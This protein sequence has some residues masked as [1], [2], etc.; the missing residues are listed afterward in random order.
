MTRRP[1]VGWLRHNFLPASETFLYQSL[2]AVSADVDVRVFALQRRY[3]EK[4]PDADVLALEGLP[5]GRLETALYRLTS[6]SPRWFAFARGVD[7]LHAHMGYTAAHALLARARTGRPLVVS[8]YGRD[9]TLAQSTSRFTDPSY[10][11]Y[12][13]LW[14]RVLTSAD[15]VCVLSEDM[16]AQLVAV[17][18]PADR[19]R[20]VRLGIDL[21][22]FDV[23]R[24]VRTGP[25]T[26]LMVGRE[27]EKKG[28]DD[29]LR[30][31]AAA[32]AAGADL[33]IVLLGTGGP[34]QRALRALADE[35]GLEVAWPDPATRVPQAMAE[36][37]ILM[38]PSRT[39]ANGDREGTPTVIC[40]AGAARLPVVATRHA[41]IPEQVE[42][43]VT[44]LL[45]D[46]RDVAGLAAHLVILAADPDRRRALGEAG[47]ARM[48][49]GFSVEAH[50]RSLSATYR[51]LL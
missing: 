39:A 12:A 19:I 45:A 32:K 42:D 34:D 13:A 4:F 15:R 20:I 21:A 9:V 31:C 27:I 18:A 22:R 35:L 40:E 33:R 41:G 11:H 43:G 48:L 10:W 28:F 5:W 26:V 1:R 7:V 51:E 37:D 24:P 47:R 30:A 25:A 44:G 36:A 6:W 46:E 38:V 23:A 8:Y 16:K 14:R 2:R 49:A 29:G 17:G 3:A 50:A